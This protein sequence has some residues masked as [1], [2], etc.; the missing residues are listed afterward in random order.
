MTGAL[1]SAERNYGRDSS[2]R[3]ERRI[4]AVEQRT[5]A[6]LIVSVWPDK[7]YVFIRDDDGTDWFGHRN[8]F[9][10]EDEWAKRARGARCG[11]LHGEWKGKPRAMSVRVG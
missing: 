1:Q 4:R 11:F 3:S 7:D 9:L 6:G 8:D 5:F 2:A 10:T